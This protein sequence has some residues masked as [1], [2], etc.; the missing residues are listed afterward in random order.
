MDYRN[1]EL[2]WRASLVP[3]KEEYPFKRVPKVAFM[4][5]TRGDLPLLQLWERFF[6]GKDVNKYSIYVHSLPGYVLS[7][8]NTSVFYKR[9][10]PS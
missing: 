9:Q 3:Y 8:S 5:L 7:V 2:F 6:D 1:D 4:L 10:I